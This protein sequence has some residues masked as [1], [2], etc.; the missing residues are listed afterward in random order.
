MTWD[1]RIQILKLK[2]VNIPTVS[3]NGTSAAFDVE[4]AETVTV[5]KHG[6]AEVKLPYRLSLDQHDQF[7]MMIHMRSSMGFKGLH[8]HIGIVDAGY[9]GDIKVKVFNNSD[10]DI[11]IEEGERFAQVT[12][13]RKYHVVFNEM[14]AEEF[15]EYS[16]DQL[17]GTKGFGSSNDFT[18]N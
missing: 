9:T 5:P 16:N 12:V 7:Y 18:R 4:A 3:Y 15:E 8:N 6:S 13:H 14:N 17:R 2:D 11:T 10:K 1:I